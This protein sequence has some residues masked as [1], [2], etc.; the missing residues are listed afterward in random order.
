MIRKGRNE[1]AMPRYTIRISNPDIAYEASDIVLPDGDRARELAV[2]LVADLF[3]SG[4]QAFETGWSSC[5][6]HVVAE[7]GE[8]VFVASAAE[9]ALIERDLVRSASA[10]LADN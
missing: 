2:R 1:F 4:P 5:S 8:A 3:S 9:A 6:I 7:D 10:S